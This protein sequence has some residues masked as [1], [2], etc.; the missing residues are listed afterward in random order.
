M[1]VRHEV[2]RDDPTNNGQRGHTVPAKTR[3]WDLPP[4]C[5]RTV[6]SGLFRCSAPLHTMATEFSPF[7]FRIVDSVRSILPPCVPRLLDFLLKIANQIA[8]MQ[9][10]RGT[11]NVAEKFLIKAS[12]VAKPD[13]YKFRVY[14]AF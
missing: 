5:Y 1:L 9:N 14:K 12:K 7:V 4:R 8:A 2:G 10:H 3:P 11:N 13:N 6:T